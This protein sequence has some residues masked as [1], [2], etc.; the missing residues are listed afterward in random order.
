MSKAGR[1]MQ[2]IQ[3]RIQGINGPATYI[4]SISR[5]EQV[6]LTDVNPTRIPEDAFPH[7]GITYISEDM[8]KEPS[9]IRSLF[10]LNI[11]CLFL[12]S[13]EYELSTWLSDIEKALAQQA[14]N[15][16]L[17]SYLIDTFIT[18][19]ERDGGFVD[20]YRVVNLTVEAP[21]TYAFGSPDDATF[22]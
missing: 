22:S 11:R 20:P 10:T 21:Y 8:E 3:E 4:N 17:N 16:G 2:K 7:F 1:I 6:S 5:P 13:S 9:F 14:P 15:L 18:K 12:N 19:K